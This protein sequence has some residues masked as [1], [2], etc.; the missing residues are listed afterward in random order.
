MLWS[1]RSQTVCCFTVCFTDQFKHMPTWRGAITFQQTQQFHS[2]EAPLRHSRA[3]QVRNSDTNAALTSKPNKQRFTVHA[4][5]MRNH[6]KRS[7]CSEY[8]I[9][10]TASG[11]EQSHFDKA[12]DMQIVAALESFMIRQR[13]ASF[14]RI[15]SVSLTDESHF[16]YHKIKF[17]S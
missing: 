3:W 11:E 10:D 1:W 7:P 9:I 8:M 5:T 17:T 6:W 14:E 13:A 15:V 4:P 2:V 12:I 16:I